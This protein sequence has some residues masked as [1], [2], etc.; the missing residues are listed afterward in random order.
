STRL[1]HSKLSEAEERA[2]IAEAIG[3]VEQSTGRRPTGWISQDFGE[4]IR[5]PALLAE[6]GLDW[7]MDWPNDDQP[8]WINPARPM[9]SIP[10]QMEWDDAQ[11]LWLRRIATPRYP[12]L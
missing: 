4:S 9:V 12:V 8:Y 5:T 2:A 7:L 3:T 11:L 6:A 1:L 10:N